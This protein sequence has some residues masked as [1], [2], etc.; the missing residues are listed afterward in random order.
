MFEN[1]SNPRGL[2]KSLVWMVWNKKFRKM[3]K[4][5]T[6]IKFL[7]ANKAKLPRVDQK[8]LQS[9]RLLHILL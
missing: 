2:E 5:P 9:Q 6:P 4:V 7:Y 1:K 3:T 8:I